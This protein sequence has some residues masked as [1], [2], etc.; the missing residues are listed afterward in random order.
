[1]FA[2][3]IQF[4]DFLKTGSGAEEYFLGG[5]GRRTQTQKKQNNVSR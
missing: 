3:Q 4:F 5:A 1:V 2:G